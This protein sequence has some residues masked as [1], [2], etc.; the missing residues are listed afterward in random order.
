MK[1]ARRIALII[2]IVVLVLLVAGF[3]VA[4]IFGLLLDVLYIFLIILA[5]FTLVSTASLVYAVL[6]LIRT[7]STVRDEVKPLLASVQDTV[8]V[9]KDTAGVVQETAKTAGHTVSTI[10]STAQ[11]TKEFALGPSVR[12]VAAV[13]AGQQVLR[14]FIGKGH[15]RSRLDR[16]RKQQ[17]EAGAGGE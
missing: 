9:V 15:V 12:A 8:G 13:V 4:G 14:V 2:G 5:A 10:G 17:M 16:R 6:M 7:I 11:L 3:I 1:G